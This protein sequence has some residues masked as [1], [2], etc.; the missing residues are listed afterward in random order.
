MFSFMFLMEVPDCFLDYATAPVH[1][2]A[3][4]IRLH[5]ETQLAKCLFVRHHSAGC[6]AHGV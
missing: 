6:S 1:V 5:F 4:A 2:C 3:D